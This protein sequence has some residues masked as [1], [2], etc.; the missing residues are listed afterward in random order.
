MDVTIA[1]LH[2]S[3][4]RYEVPA[5]PGQVAPFFRGAPDNVVLPESFVRV[6]AT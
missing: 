4:H 5:R 3:V 2:I 1:N 6:L